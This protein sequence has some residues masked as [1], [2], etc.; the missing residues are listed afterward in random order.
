MTARLFA[1]A[2]VRSAC[3]KMGLM[4]FAGS[5]KTYT[6]TATAMSRSL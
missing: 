3:L 2:E 1:P 4:G 6:A 5:G